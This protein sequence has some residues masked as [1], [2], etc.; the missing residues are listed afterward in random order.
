MIN[1]MACLTRADLRD[2]FT[3][4]PVMSSSRSIQFQKGLSLPSFLQQFGS[5]EQCQAAVSHMR[6]PDGFICPRCG[7]AH[8]HVL[9]TRSL[10][11]CARC[12]KQTSLTANTLFHS[13]KLSLPTW[14]LGLYSISQTKTGMPTLGLARYL[15][16]Q[17]DT[18]WMILHKTMV[19]ME[20]REANRVLKQH[21]EVDDAYL[22]GHLHDQK[23]GR[24]SPDN[25]PFLPAI[26]SPKKVD[27]CACLS[28]WSRGFVKPP[29]GLGSPTGALLP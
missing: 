6:W 22:G 18:A 4:G 15:G 16:V 7:H 26:E 1:K 17:Q 13:T 3:K 23:V 24:R 14:F 5:V 21:I 25:V 11:Q 27:R 9:P 29:S 12:R 19:S 10:V 20:K 8:G 28:L 2:E